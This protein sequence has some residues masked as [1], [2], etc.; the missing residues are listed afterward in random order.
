[1]RKWHRW[2]SLFFGIFMLW[3]AVTGVLSQVAVLWPAG[4][5]DPAVEALAT[6][7]EGFECPEGWR[8]MP[9]RAS[10]GIRS[11]VG[12]FHHLHS[13]ETFG[14]IGT[15]I[16][17]LS[18]LALVFFSISGIWLYVQMW[19]FRTKRKLTPRWFWK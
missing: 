9:P 12:L 19:R 13:G 1:M 5:P 7:P 6:P 15:V 3:I 10:G 2:L 11:M 4:A 17:V 8:C 14:A 16:S 18:G